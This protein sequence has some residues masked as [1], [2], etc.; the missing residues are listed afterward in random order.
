M[1]LG[2]EPAQ[3]DPIYIVYMRHVNLL[4]CIMRISTASV[5]ILLE[6]RLKLNWIS[7]LSIGITL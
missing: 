7:K 5:Y 6:G 2:Y 3:D 1:N 4:V